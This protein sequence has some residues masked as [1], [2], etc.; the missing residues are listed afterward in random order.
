MSALQTS[1][2]LSLLAFFPSILL[3]SGVSEVAKEFEE[4][5]ST[6]FTSGMLVLDNEG[7]EL[8][9]L[10]CIIHEVAW[11]KEIN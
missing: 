8:D 1:I 4:T 11:F 6:H 5:S 2:L 10:V 7:V 3:A 9:V